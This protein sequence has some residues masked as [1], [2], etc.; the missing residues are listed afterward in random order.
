[1]MVTELIDQDDF[2]ERLKALGVCLPSDACPDVAARLALSK[3]AASGVEGLQELVRE[4]MD[5][6]DILL[7][8]VRQA[9]ERYLLPGLR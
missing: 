6:R 4:L 3:H 9:L 7:P 5:K 1:M 8:S 2:R